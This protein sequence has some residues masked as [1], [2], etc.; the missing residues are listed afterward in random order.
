[1]HA[2]LERLKQLF[3]EAEQ[4]IS[5]GELQL[6]QQRDTVEKRLRFG[7]D[8]EHAMTLLAKLEKSQQ[9]LLKER[10]RLRNKLAANGTAPDR[11][12]ERAPRP[13]PSSDSERCS[14]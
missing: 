5:P 9:L 11:E 1:M 4:A 2:K 7:R 14:T 13:Q 6:K 10:D 3:E 8:L 12:I